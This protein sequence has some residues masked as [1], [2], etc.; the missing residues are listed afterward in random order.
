LPFLPLPRWPLASLALLA[1][2]DGALAQSPAAQRAPVSVDA[3]RISGRTDGVTEAE[4]KVE[5]QQ[6]P[7]MLRADRLRYD[8]QSD[9]VRA[10]GDVRIDRLGDRYRGRELDLGLTNL[11]G[12]FL[13]PEYFFSRSQA[14][15]RADRI[16]FIDAKRSELINATYTSCGLDGSG[17]PAWLLSADEVRLD[18]D[19]NEGRA[20]GAVLRFYGV[21][22]LA[23]PVLSF[24]LTDERKSGWLPPSINL[25][26][27]TGLEVGVPYYWNIAPHRDATLTP[28]L[29]TRRGLATDA[30]FRYLEPRHAGEIDLRWLPHDRVEN[31]A[32]WGLHLRHTGE[33]PRDGRYAVDALGVS[34]DRYWKDFARAVPSITPRLLSQH[35]RAEWALPRVWGFDATAYA[36]LQ[37]WQV[38]DDTDP[39]ATFVGPYQRSPQ[40]GLRAARRGSAGWTL[41]VETEFNRFTRPSDDV[42]INPLT[43]DRWHALAHLAWPWRTPWA[44]LTP[45]LTLNLASYRTDQPMVDGRRSAS[46][47]IPTVAIDS[48]LRLERETSFLGRALTQTLEPRLQFVH[49]PRRA[50]TTLPNFDAAGLDFNTVSIYSPNAFAGIDRVSDAHHVTAGITS[51][52]LDATTGSE[53]MRAGVVQRLLLRDQLLTP[54][55]IAD[56]QR[57]SDVLLFGGAAIARRWTLEGALQYSPNLDRTVRSVI[58]ARYSPGPLRTVSASYR[59]VRSSS[60]QLDVGWQW[61]VWERARGSSANGCSGSLYSVGRLNYSLR[62]S[63]VTDSLIGVEYDAGCWIGRVVA[64]RLSTGRS[65]ATTRLLFQLE[66]VGL[67][68]LGSNPLQVLKDNIPGYRLL[69]EERDTTPPIPVYD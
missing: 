48:G 67:S 35:A 57:V 9:R 15:G 45:S 26:N 33:L 16:H 5:L 2:G 31:R 6:G 7:L 10:T 47:A 60:E 12:Y 4:G 62:D 28:I 53:V 37:H 24:A 39:A 38:L 61:P 52:W 69:R 18:F 42:A 13:A 27:R 22:I 14:G 11:D 23:A 41:A 43:G 30:E 29:M 32:R 50:Q 34:D 44:W 1:L 66:L 3:D 56:T 59:I 51:R 68:R 63:R 65:E 64:E 25:D 21:P 49:T 58:G 20:E 40:L 55:G 46:R 8:P 17:A 36:R 19:R 54:A